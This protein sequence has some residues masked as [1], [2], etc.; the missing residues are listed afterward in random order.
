MVRRWPKQFLCSYL[1]LHSFLIGP[2]GTVNYDYIITI[3]TIGPKCIHKQ[4]LSQMLQNLWYVQYVCVYV[5][6]CVRV[7]VYVCVYVCVC[8]SVRVYMCVHV[9]MWN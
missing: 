7:C 5:C 1:S 2:D 4:L 6:V 9:Y 8:E 3:L